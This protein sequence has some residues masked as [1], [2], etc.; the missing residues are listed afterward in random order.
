MTKPLTIE[1]ED[2][3]AEQLQQIA[4]DLGETPEQFA[5]Q[6]VAARVEAFKAN[7]F[8]ARRA[9]GLDRDAARNWLADQAAREDA[10]MPDA[11]D[12]VPADYVRPR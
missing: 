9:K 2:A 8:F 11:D 10:P 12:V 5:A 6:A 7:A 1:I 3:A 4:N